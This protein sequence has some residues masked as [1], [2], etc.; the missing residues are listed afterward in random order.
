MNN[1]NAT[2]SNDNTRHTHIA[3]NAKY[4]D[5]VFCLIYTELGE[6]SV[7]RFRIY[8]CVIRQS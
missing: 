7:Q 6:N 8:C 5:D 2:I 1:Y 4:D 3:H